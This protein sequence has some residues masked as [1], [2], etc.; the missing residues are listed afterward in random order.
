MLEKRFSVPKTAHV[1]VLVMALGILP[2]TLSPAQE[3]YFADNPVATNNL[4][5]QKSEQHISPSFNSTT[6]W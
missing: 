4:S 5:I 6:K 1:A 2:A 3:K